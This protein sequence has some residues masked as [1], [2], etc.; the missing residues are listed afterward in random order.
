MKK[1]PIIALAWVLG[2]G[3]A[4]AETV[5]IPVIQ[6]EWIQIAGDPD[7]GPYTDPGQQPVD[8]AV[9]QAADGTWQLWSCIRKTRCGGNTRLFYR[10]QGEELT[11]PDWRPMGI[12]MEADPAF[13]ETPGGLQAPHVIR[14]LGDYYMFYG[15][16]EHICLA[17]GWDGKTFA[18]LIDENLRAGMFSEGGGANT[19]DAMALF[20]DGTYYCYY[21]AHPGRRGAVY[22]RTSIDLRHWSES[23]KVAYGGSAGTEFYNAECPHVVKRGDWFYL[24]RTQRY[25]EN[26][27][28]SVYRSKN[29]LDFGIEDD[30]YLVTR[31]PVAAPEIIVHEGGYFIASLVPSLKGIRIAPLAWE[32]RETE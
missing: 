23:V 25:G 1:I 17:K 10:W 22:C 27:Q 12:A 32:A 15:D 5:E 8:F 6:G 30:R 9:W 7:L 13:G 20:A 21:T 26:A 19:R 24:F 3:A 2:T 31:L 28:T 16:W 14:V 4:L 29:P 11:A 18:R